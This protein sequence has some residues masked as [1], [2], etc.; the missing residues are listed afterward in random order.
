V[1]DDHLG[2]TPSGRVAMATTGMVVAMAFAATIPVSGGT[3]SRF[4]GGP[5]P[6][7]V[8]LR[9]ASF[10]PSA[11]SVPATSLV[12]SGVSISWPPASIGSATVGYQVVRADDVGGVAT[13]CTGPWSPTP[14]AGAVTCIDASVQP[15]RTY[16]YSQRAV[17]LRDGVETW[18]QAPS[19]ES[20]PLLVPPVT[21]GPRLVYAS[22]SPVVPST[23]PGPITL[24]YPSGTAPGDLLLLVSLGGRTSLPVAPPGWGVAAS[25]STRGSDSS[26]L[27]VAWRSAD[28]GSSV[29]FDPQSNSAGAV[30]RLIRY[31]RAAGLADV[32]SL[33]GTPT[34]GTCA[35]GPTCASS[36][37]TTT[38]P[39]A[40]V[41]EIAAVREAV[42]MGLAPGT[43]V[44]RMLETL[45]PG[46]VALSVGLAD[47]EAAL[48]GP[49]AGATWQQDGSTADW[50][51]ASVSFR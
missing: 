21:V 6:I 31:A 51:W 41:V 26:H 10:A 5:P 42:A 25:V 14:S 30:T 7:A 46:R 44:I 35:P 4:T 34:S 20:A 2:L 49:V 12:S 28:A 32:V 18:S 45:N 33:A 36:G 15:G 40:T 3:A 9:A 16:R 1:R 43:A 11:A 13:V 37:T 22:S 50:L 47:S 19:P 27:L 8:A 23:K 29:S 38:G 17:L 24:P 48:A 39:S